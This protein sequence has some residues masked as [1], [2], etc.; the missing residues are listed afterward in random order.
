VSLLDAKTLARFV[1][2][3]GD[4]LQGEWVVIGGC[5]LPLLG[6]EHRITVDIDIAGPDD[7]DM[8][9]MLVL[10]E[11]AEELGLPV[12]TINQ[13]GSHFLRQIEDWPEHLVEIHRGKTATLHVPDATL[14]LLLKLRRLSEADLLDCLEM[15]GLARR[16]QGVVDA[17]RVRTVARETLKTARAPGRRARIKKLLR[18]LDRAE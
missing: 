15:L 8:G 17:E 7:T 18:A 16:R 11:I 12:E 6:V 5:V 14:F 10:M 4:R 13:A 9:R 2:L 1:A 3:A